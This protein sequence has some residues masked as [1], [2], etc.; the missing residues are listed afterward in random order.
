MSWID[1]YEK[2][3]HIESGT[4][5]EAVREAERIARRRGDSGYDIDVANAIYRK[6]IKKYYRRYGVRKKGWFQKFIDW[7]FGSNENN[8]KKY[9]R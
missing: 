6:K 1:K 2:D 7:L 9:R 5:G 3:S 4:W 8:F